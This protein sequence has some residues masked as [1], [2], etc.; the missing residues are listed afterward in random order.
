MTPALFTIADEIATC[1]QGRHHLVVLGAG[2]SI[3]AFPN[4]DRGG[5]RLPAMKNFVDILELEGLLQEHGIEP[6]YDNFEALYS[7]I[8]TEPARHELKK[9]IEER[10]YSYFAGL[11]LPDT[12][13]L[14]DHLILS[15]RPKDVIATFNWDP[16]L[17]QAAARNHR[18]GGVPRLLFLHGNVAIG[19]CPQ[20][21]VVLG[22]DQM[23]ARCGKPLVASPLLYPVKKKELPIRPCDCES[24]AQPRRGTEGRV[25]GDDF[26]LLRTNNRCR[27]C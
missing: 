18:F 20:C 14:Y 16:F 23:C 22:R 5:K 27:S 19:Y 11:S 2:A 26:W 17:W 6:P 12:P 25:G 7:D 4:G 21:K 8:A 1:E 13:T 3:A 10:V 15:L 24:L 9:Q